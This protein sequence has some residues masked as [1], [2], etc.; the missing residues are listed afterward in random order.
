MNQRFKRFVL[1]RFHKDHKGAIAR[2]FLQILKYRTSQ[3]HEFVLSNIVSWAREY[4]DQTGQGVSV[5]ER[6]DSDEIIEAL[7]K[8]FA[9]ELAKIP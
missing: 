8:K 9:K 5:H 2:L 4:S 1:E 7:Q 6:E 3:V